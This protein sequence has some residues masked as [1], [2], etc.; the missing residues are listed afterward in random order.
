M[1]LHAPLGNAEYGGLLVRLP[2]GAYFGLQGLSKLAN[3]VLFIEEVRKAKPTLMGINLLTEPLGSLYGI[4]LPYMEIIV[5]AL[6]IVGM[7]TTLASILSSLMLTSFILAV[8]WL[9]KSD[10]LLFNKDFVLLGASL[11]LLYIGGGAFSV[12]KFRRSG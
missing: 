11:S 3:P 8:G 7:W 10:P 4:L 6:L 12:D 9:V 5:G 1:K 2:L